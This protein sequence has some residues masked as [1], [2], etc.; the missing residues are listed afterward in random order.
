MT[1]QFNRGIVFTGMGILLH[2]AYSAA[3]WRQLSRYADMTDMVLPLDIV[4]QTLL[5]LL[6]TMFGVIHIAGDF[7]EVRATVE[8]ETKSWETLRNRPSFYTFSNRGRVFSPFYSPPSSSK[9]V[10]DIPDRF[11]S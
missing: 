8:L 5:A 9:K 10:L 6:L 4:L 3:E 1:N 11:M 7:K 2:A